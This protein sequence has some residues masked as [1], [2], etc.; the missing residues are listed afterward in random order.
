MVRDVVFIAQ[1]LPGKQV[2]SIYAEMS[3]SL[4]SSVIRTTADIIEELMV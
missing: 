2:K 3:Q 1:P 4:Q